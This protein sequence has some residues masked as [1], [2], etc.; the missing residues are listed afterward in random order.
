MDALGSVKNLVLY[1][2]SLS[3]LDPELAQYMGTGLKAEVLERVTIVD[4]EYK[5]I[6]ARLRI[7]LKNPSVEIFGVDPTSI[8][9]SD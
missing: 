3:P 4:P 7:F 9:F 5:A 8:A 2:L 6:A 1:G